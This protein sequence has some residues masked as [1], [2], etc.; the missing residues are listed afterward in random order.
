MSGLLTLFHPI[1]ELIIFEILQNCNLSDLPNLFCICIVSKNIM[2]KYLRPVFD[3]YNNIVN[4]INKI[5]CIKIGND[6][7]EIERQFMCSSEMENILS[8][9][10]SNFFVYD[11]SKISTKI[12]LEIYI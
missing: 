3:N 2:D 7:P 12:Y 10:I 8:R 11:T 5:H 1:L 4:A 9:M 6:D